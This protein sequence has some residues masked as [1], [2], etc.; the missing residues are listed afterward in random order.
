M[1][2]VDDEKLICSNIKCNKMHTIL[3]DI[4]VTLQAFGFI[5]SLLLITIKELFVKLNDMSTPA[6]IM[7]SKY[8]KGTNT[9]IIVHIKPAIK[10]PLTKFPFLSISVKIFGNKPSD[11]KAYCNLGCAKKDTNTTNGNVTIS[12]IATIF[13]A[14]G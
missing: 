12:P 3:N 7:S 11:D 10:I 13:C 9:A 14:K 5:G 2:I 4:N 1:I 8:L 6:D